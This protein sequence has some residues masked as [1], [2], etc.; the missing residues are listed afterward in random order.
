MEA[1][2]NIFKESLTLLLWPLLHSKNKFY[3]TEFLGK[4]EEGLLQVQFLLND[5]FKKN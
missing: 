4:L 5:L 3:E 2:T 1:H